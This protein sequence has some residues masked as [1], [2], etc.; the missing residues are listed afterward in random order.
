[1]ELGGVRHRESYLV[2]GVVF[3]DDR[4]LLEGVYRDGFVYDTRT[5]RLYDLERPVNRIWKSTLSAML[6]P[7]IQI[8]HIPEVTDRLGIHRESVTI[9]LDAPVRIFRHGGLVIR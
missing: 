4:F 8:R 2:N 9:N 1:M 3:V 5:G 7:M 6:P